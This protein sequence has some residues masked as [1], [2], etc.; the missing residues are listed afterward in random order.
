MGSKT[1]ED[2]IDFSLIDLIDHWLEFNKKK[3]KI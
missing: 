3:K 2:S 1:A